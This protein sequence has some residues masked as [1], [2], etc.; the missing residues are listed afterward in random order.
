MSAGHEIHAI[1]A[2]C[3]FYHVYIP[4]QVPLNQSFTAIMNN[5][6]YLVLVVI[7]CAE[8]TDGN[9]CDY[10]C[11]CTKR[12]EGIFA[13]C[14][15]GNLNVLPVFDDL[16]AVMLT[17]LDV[18]DNNIRNLDQDVIE[19]WQSLKGVSLLKNPLNCTQLAFFTDDTFILSECLLDKTTVTGK[20]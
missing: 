2:L 6:V 10:N 8:K 4:H 3:S 17:F 16:T 9:F 19:T 1:F 5:L 12:P 18:S 20:F 7:L 14:S 11:Y 15:S 13:D